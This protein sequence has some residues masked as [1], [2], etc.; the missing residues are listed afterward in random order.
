MKHDFNRPNTQTIPHFTGMPC[1][2]VDCVKNAAYT[3][4]LNDRN[5]V[6]VNSF[7]FPDY[8]RLGVSA[9]NMIDHA[10]SPIQGQFVYSNVEQSLYNKPGEKPSVSRPAGKFLGKFKAFNSSKNWI[11]VDYNGY[12]KWIS[13]TRPETFSF[14]TPEKTAPLS[15][16]DKLKIGV[17]V[18]SLAGPAAAAGGLVIEKVAI[19]VVEKTADII[20]GL[21]PY[22]KWILILLV[23]AIVGGVFLRAKG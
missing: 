4:Q 15:S 1:D 6:Y 11:V 9:R 19:P 18:G 20:S 21:G 13:Y 22:L 7:D 17:K 14:R 5:A 10:D 23:V 12:E 16:M 8:D 3:K 2:C